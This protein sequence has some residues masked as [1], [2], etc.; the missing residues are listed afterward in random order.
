[1]RSI[2]PQVTSMNSARSS[3]GC[4]G[5]GKPEVHGEA[6]VTE[7]G[8]R[9]GELK[10]VGGEDHVLAFAALYTHPYCGVLFLGF[11]QGPALSSC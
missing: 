6:G 5:G 4:D 1:M 3:A 8:I 11:R 7:R 9:G 10:R 2:I